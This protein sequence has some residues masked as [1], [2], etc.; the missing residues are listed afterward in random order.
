MLQSAASQ[1]Q[2]VVN[3]LTTGDPVNEG[4]VNKV[5]DDERAAADS[6]L[7]AKGGPTAKIQVNAILCRNWVSSAVCCTCVY[8]STVL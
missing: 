3:I 6:G 8:M 7:L 1:S 4:D 5:E 2:H